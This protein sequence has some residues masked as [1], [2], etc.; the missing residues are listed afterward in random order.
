[1]VSERSR[2]EYGQEEIKIMNADSNAYDG[3]FARLQVRGLSNIYPNQNDMAEKITETFFDRNAVNALIIAQC[4]SGK[5]GVMVSLV[6][7]FMK[8]VIIPL[9]NI[10]IITGLSSLDWKNQTK[11][12]FPHIMEPRIFHRSDLL[13]KFKN[14]MEEKRQN[15]MDK[16]LLIIIDELQI[17]AKKEQTIDG[18]FKNF[19]FHDKDELFKKDIKIVE[20]SATPD[21]TLYDIMKWGQASRKLLMQPSKD[22][23]GF[24]SLKE[25]N[26]FFQCEDLRIKENVENLKRVIDGRFGEESKFHIIRSFPKDNLLGNFLTVFGAEECHI[27][28]YDED[29]KRKQRNDLDI[30]EILNSEPPKKYTF[31][32]IKEMLRCAKT[33]VTEQ[34]GVLY[35]RYTKNPDDS[36]STQGL[37]G[38]ACGFNR[39]EIIIFTSLRSINN[40]LKLWDCEFEDKSIQWKSST[41][42]NVK[43]MITS[44]KTSYNFGAEK[45][46]NEVTQTLQEPTV[47][48]FDSFKELKDYFKDY[49]IDYLNNK[50]GYKKR[51]GPKERRV[52]EE[53][54]Y[55]ADIRGHKSVISLEHALRERR[56]NVRNGANYGIRPCYTNIQDNKSLKWVLIY[57]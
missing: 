44:V 15:G 7:K 18:M 26:R 1:M 36:V 40:Y 51:T 47:K 28:Y 16:N 9:E 52:N 29:T 11:V 22:Y 12:R 17:A 42:K 35:E 30:N 43:G 46:N 34:I 3:D 38:R 4:Q 49:L 14:D 48:T 55:E 39:H 10:Y 33:I 31:V 5:T 54:F 27:I 21:G 37:A 25:N 50:H 45:T 2:F 41:T 56:C 6:G 53:G 24:K 23:I 19:G 57:Y 13:T 32:F 8:E 20:F